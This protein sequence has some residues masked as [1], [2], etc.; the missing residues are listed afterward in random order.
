MEAVLLIVV[1]GIL[2][3]LAVGR[4]WVL[5]APVAL[6][7]V[8]GLDETEPGSDTPTWFIA[9]AAGVVMVAATALGVGARKL[10]ARRS[11]GSAG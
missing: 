1:A 10:L 11:R 3:G 7:L 9:L 6:G 4:W 5:L 8:I 2:L